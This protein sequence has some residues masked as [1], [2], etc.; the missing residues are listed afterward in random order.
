MCDAP[1]DPYIRSSQPALSES[2]R[3]WFENELKKIEAAFR[4]V[5]AVINTKQDKP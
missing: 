3:L 5:A 4:A 2:Q 1:K